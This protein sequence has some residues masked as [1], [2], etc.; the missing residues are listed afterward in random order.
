MGKIQAW[1][2]PLSLR[3]FT[4]DGVFAGISINPC[5]G[6]TMTSIGVELFG[7]HATKYAP[8]G[9]LTSSMDYGFGIFGTM[10]VDVPG[11]VTPIE[12]G[13]EIRESGGDV[14]LSADMKTDWTDALGI[15]NL[16]V[17]SAPCRATKLLL[18]NIYTD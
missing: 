6:L 9:S 14:S 12:L 1:N 3:S 11:S 13:F 4:L 18:A 10:H 8:D 7:F 17:S 16:T 2:S 15:K 5:N